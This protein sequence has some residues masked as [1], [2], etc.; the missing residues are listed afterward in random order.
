MAAKRK[1]DSNQPE[2]PARGTKP[3]ATASVNGAADAKA[4][5]NGNGNG[6]AHIH[7]ETV[8][9]EV[10]HHRMDRQDDIGSLLID[11][12]ADISPDF[13]IKEVAFIRPDAVDQA[14]VKTHPLR[15]TPQKRIVE[16]SERTVEFSGFFQWLSNRRDESV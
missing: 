8:P 4:T 14:E 1:E 3:E 15:T 11:E 7:T 12:S 5:A 13:R 6:E 9:E 2:L 16:A 10:I